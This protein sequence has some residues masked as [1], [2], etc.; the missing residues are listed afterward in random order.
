M[1]LDGAGIAILVSVLLW[2][3]R[4]RFSASGAWSHIRWIL[5]FGLW[6][7]RSP[8]L[9]LVVPVL[10]SHNAPFRSIGWVALFL[11]VLSLAIILFKSLGPHGDEKDGEASSHNG[12]PT[13]GFLKPL[14]FPSRTTHARFFP[15]KHSF[16]YSYLLVGFPIGWRGNAGSLLSADDGGLGK[17]GWLRVDAADYLY[18]GDDPRGL[19][20]KLDSYL[21]T[22][23]I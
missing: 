14:I 4:L 19:K 22:Q 18:R 21:E 5:L 9:D 12:S 3:V 15:K 13:K 23:V 10:P 6:I 11:L 7:E 16:S 1:R 2:A 17:R 20:G 8:I